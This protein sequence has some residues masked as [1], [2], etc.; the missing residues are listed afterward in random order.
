[1]TAPLNVYSSFL[2]VRLVITGFAA[3][4]GLAF[5]SFLNVCLTRWPEGESVVKPRSHCRTCNR[6][7]AWW[8]NVPL[9]SWL[10]LCG[11]CRTCKTAIGWRYPLVELAVG[12]LWGAAAW[13]SGGW[14]L[15][16][17][18]PAISFWSV[19]FSVVGQMLFSWL[20]VALAALDVENLWL[21][22]WLTLPGSAIG[23]AFA[24]LNPV[25]EPNFDSVTL[26][27]LTYSLEYLQTGLWRAA[28]VRVTAILAA[29]SIVLLIR[30]TYWLIRKQ[31]GMG[32][33]D[34]KLM[35]MLAA[36]LGLSGAVLSFVLAV[37][38]G[39]AFAFVVLAQPRA[40]RGAK[41]WAATPLPFG[42]FLCIAGIVSSI[43]GQQIISAYLRWS[44]LR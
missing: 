20:L 39:A 42:T 44:G 2:M 33:G 36:W 5:G 3:L 31:E 19:L 26:R 8:E 22:N 40:R 21:P 16:P 1:M 25:F 30:W 14:A 7:L 37:C 41:S 23:F 24:I 11:R 15:S 4:L 32:L 27:P 28:L 12:A 29:A 34:T 35:A 43:W 17:G 10:A 9:V 38:M 18:V 6:T 13:R